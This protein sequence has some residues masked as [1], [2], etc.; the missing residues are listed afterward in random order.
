MAADHSVVDPT[1]FL[2]DAGREDGDH[3]TATAVEPKQR[4]HAMLLR[5]FALEVTRLSLG[6]IRVMEVTAL[7]SN[8]CSKVSDKFKQL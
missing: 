8:L 1:K 3:L 2:Q 5:C 4:Q 7:K 6:A